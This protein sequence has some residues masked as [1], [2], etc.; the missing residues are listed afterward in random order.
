MKPTLSDK[1]KNDSTL[2]NLKRQ[3]KIVFRTWLFATFVFL[4]ICIS[5]G[6]MNQILIL[7]IFAVLTAT[8]VFVGSMVEEKSFEKIWNRINEIFQEDLKEILNLDDKPRS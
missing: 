8:T 7:I 4:T 5:A 2:I 6:A 1:L 3:R